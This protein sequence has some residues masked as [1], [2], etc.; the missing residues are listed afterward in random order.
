MVIP[1]LDKDDLIGSCDAYLEARTGKYEWRRERYEAALVAMDRIGLE[2]KDTIIDVGAGWTEL[3]HCLRVEGDWRGRYIPVDG[4]IDATDLEVWNPPREAE[5]FVALELLEHLDDPQ[6]LMAAMQAKATK[7]VIV[8]TPNPETTDVLGMDPTHRTEI[9][10]ALLWAFGF[11]VYTR[12]FYGQ[13]DDSLFGI[14]KPV[15]EC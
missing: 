13:V 5:Y 10:K 9:S 2:D 12:S 3:D 8:S 1:T 14:W 4:S 6:R 7:G 15:R 11:E